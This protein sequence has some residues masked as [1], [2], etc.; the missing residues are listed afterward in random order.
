MMF[1]LHYKM[2][3]LL[4]F[5]QGVAAIFVASAEDGSGEANAQEI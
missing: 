3:N 5:F 2:L 4:N 1:I